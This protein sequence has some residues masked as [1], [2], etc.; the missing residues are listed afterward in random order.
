MAR[1][2]GRS[3]FLGIGIGIVLTATTSLLYTNTIGFSKTLNREQIMEQ[4]RKYGMIDQT[5]KQVFSFEETKQEEG[6]VEPTPEAQK[7]LEVVEPQAY[8]IIEVINGD[9]VKSIGDRL[10]AVGL[11]NS[12]EFCTRVKKLDLTNRM[13]TGKYKIIKGEVLDRIIDILSM[14]Y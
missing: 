13:S 11:V 12:K 1:I 7:Q 14:S 8:A 10:E 9:T 4:A 5:E 6:K 2:Q 3:L